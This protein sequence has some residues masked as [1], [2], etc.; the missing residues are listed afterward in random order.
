MRARPV[1]T[2]SVSL[3]QWV[4][5]VVWHRRMY[6]QSRFRWVQEDPFRIATW[7]TRGRIVH[8]TPRHLARL[9][10]QLLELRAHIEEICDAI[11]A[12]TRR[13]RA[14]AGGHESSEWR[15][16]LALAG[17]EPG[18]IARLERSASG[19]PNSEATNHDVQRTL[20]GF[21]CPNPVTEVW[22]LAQ[23]EAMYSAAELLLEDTFCDLAAELAAARSWAGLADFTTE[24]DGDNLRRRVARQRSTRGPEGDPRRQRGLVQHYE[25]VPQIT[26]GDDW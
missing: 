19:R 10:E 17:Q 1:R 16:C 22:E 15:M 13:I 11:A 23:L 12:R 8:E 25:P 6:R 20:R 21:P 9:D 2:A 24:T 5:D 7:F 4:E 18:T 3:E 14:A 26:L